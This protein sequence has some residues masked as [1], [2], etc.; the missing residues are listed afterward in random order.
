MGFWLLLCGYAGSIIPDYFLPTVWT[1][2]A[3]LT[4]T[5]VGWIVG[6]L[7]GL[8]VYERWKNL[9]RDGK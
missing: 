3:Q 8:I 9:G 2:E 5:I 7:L 6:I 4:Q 1:W